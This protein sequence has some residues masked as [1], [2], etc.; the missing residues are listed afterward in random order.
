MARAQ[1]ST[2]YLIILAVVIILAL[3]VVGVLGGIPS[4]GSSSRRRTSEL[5]WGSADIAL[6]AYSFDAAGAA[7]V[8][9]VR[10]NLR[11][12]ITIRDITIE[13]TSAVTSDTTLSSGESVTFS[14]SGIASHKDCGSSGDSYSY[15]VRVNYTDDDTG[16]NYSFSGSGTPL[17]GSCSG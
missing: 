13:G 3:I 6:T 1:A 15:T 11:G 9:K 2:E 12:G 16:A 4:I 17:E 8:L 7:N 5:Y 10:N 14:G